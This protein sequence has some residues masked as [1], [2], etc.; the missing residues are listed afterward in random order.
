[1][2]NGESSDEAIVDGYDALYE[3]IRYWVE[4]QEALTNVPGSN[5]FDELSGEPDMLDQ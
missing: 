1:M 3:N 5:V 4:Q 2:T